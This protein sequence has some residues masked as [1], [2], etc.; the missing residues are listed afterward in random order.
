M[1]ISEVTRRNIF[2]LLRVEKTSWN[3]RLNE[4]DFLSRMFNLNKMRSFDYRFSNAA[5]DIYQHRI[6]NWDWDD[7]WIYGDPRFDFLHCEDEVFLQFLCEMIHPVVRP[8]ESEV[9]K[10]LKMFNDNLAIDG[11]QIVEVA[12]ISN[13]QVFAGRPVDVE[14]NIF[15]FAI[16]VLS[17]SMPL[18]R[19]GISP[20][21]LIIS[22]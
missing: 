1:S 17:F 21:P 5:G 13:K 12:R 6:N 10:L 15:H 19:R 3:G 18:T 7:G 4:V 14:L 20:A 2:D 22:W 16:E 9:A 8:D 11:W